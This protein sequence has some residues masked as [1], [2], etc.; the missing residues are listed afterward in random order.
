MYIGAMKRGPKACSGRVGVTPTPDHV[1]RI[2]LTRSPPS[3]SCGPLFLSSPLLSATARPGG[4]TRTAGNLTIVRLMSESTD[5]VDPTA[6]PDGELGAELM[7]AMIRLR[8]RLRS[9]SAPEDTRWSWSQITT[10]SRIHE[11][12]PTTITELANREH[13]RRQSMAETVAALKVGKL[14]STRPDPDDARKSLVDVTPAGRELARGVP[15]ARESWLDATIDD[16]L[17]DREQQVLKQAIRLL[18]RIAESGKT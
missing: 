14:V 6:V 1:L 5:G 13:V 7:K 11:L 8:A 17:T 12:A 9:E 2:V 4:P 15:L 18:N 16:L 3:I 10:L